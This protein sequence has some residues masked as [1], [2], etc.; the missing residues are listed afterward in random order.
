MA[1]YMYKNSNFST[2][3][4]SLTTGIL[5]GLGNTDDG[6][7]IMKFVATGFTRLPLDSL[8]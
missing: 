2:Y 8:P 4:R 7:W 5:V 1:Q 3:G 6:L